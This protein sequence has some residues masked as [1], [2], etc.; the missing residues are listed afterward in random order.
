MVTFCMKKESPCP[1]MHYA[2]DDDDFTLSNVVKSNIYI[3]R[4]IDCFLNL[5][6]CIYET[7][8]NSFIK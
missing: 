8:K 5:I 6:N 7:L 2:Y 1:W 3:S 4:E